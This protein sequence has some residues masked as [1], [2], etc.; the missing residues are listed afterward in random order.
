MRTAFFIF[1]VAARFGRERLSKIL[2]ET[3]K[4]ES[5]SITS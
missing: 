4:I 5:M 2:V 1:I 3:N